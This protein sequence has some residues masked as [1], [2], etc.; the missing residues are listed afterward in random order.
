[1]RIL[2]FTEGTI[3]DDRKPDEEWNM[4][5]NATRKLQAWREHGATI[6][7]LSSKTNPET[8]S[9]VRE[10]LWKGGA[11]EGELFFRR[12]HEHYGQAAERASPD[13][14]VEDDCESIG[15]QADMTYPKLRPDVKAR[16][17]SVVIPEWG[18]IDELPDDPDKLRK[19]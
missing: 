9:K 10:A 6:L 2:V 17:K 15:G 4:V 16:T 19:D 3:L 11:P 12:E 7:Y 18:G 8:L 5:G 1:M 13:V 14:I